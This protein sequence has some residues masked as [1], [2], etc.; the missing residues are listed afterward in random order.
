MFFEAFKEN[1]YLSG[2]EL[3]KIQHVKEK[4]TMHICLTKLW[5]LYL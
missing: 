3:L 5:S 1:F 4:K 2:L